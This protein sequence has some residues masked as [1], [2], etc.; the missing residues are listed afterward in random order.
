MRILEFEKCRNLAIV[1]Q[2]RLN[3]EFSSFLVVHW[4]SVP[5]GLY[6]VKWSNTQSNFV[7]TN[8]NRPVKF[9]RLIRSS[10]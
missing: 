4:H 1:G 6:S 5:F 10:S 2:I 7:N 8:T 9:V 3:F